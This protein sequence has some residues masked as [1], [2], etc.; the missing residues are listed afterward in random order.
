MASTRPS[1]AQS[2]TRRAT[3]IHQD[4]FKSHYKT[5]DGLIMVGRYPGDPVAGTQVLE[6]VWKANH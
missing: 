2:R 4:T 1:C 5:I 6:S 3:I